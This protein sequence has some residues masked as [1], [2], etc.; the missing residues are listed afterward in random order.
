[1][2]KALKINLSGQIFHIDEDAYEKLRLYLDKISSH[3]SNVEESKEIISDIEARISE[4]F[5]EKVK[6]N[7]QV[8]TIQDVEEIIDIM[9]KPEEIA[10]EEDKESR[11]T[12]SSSESRSNRR[13]YRDP[14]KAVVG[15]VAAGLS[16]YFGL[17]VVVFRIL[18]VVL[19]LVGWGFPLI[20]YIV[21]WIAVPNAIT[22]A[23]KLEMKGEKVNVSNL[24]KKVR[25][26]YEGV[27]DNLKKARSSETARRA[28]SFF[29]EFF[30]IIGVIILLFFKIILAII[31]VSLVIAGISLIA[32]LIGVSFF[33]ASAISF[34]GFGT[35]HLEFNEIIMPF[36]N[37]V[38]LSVIAIAGT[39]LV[40]IPILAILYGLFKAIFKFKTRDRGLGMSA[41]ALW[42][43]ALITT[44][45]LVVVEA[46][47]FSKSDTI[48]T[49]ISLDE[50]TSDTLF[51]S[52]DKN[53]IGK[54]KGEDRL[55]INDKWYIFEEENMIYGEVRLDIE[56]SR[57]DKVEMRIEKESRGT[58]EYEAQELAGNISY[59]YK[60]ENNVLVLDPYFHVDMDDKWRFQ[61]IDITIY[62]PEGKAVNLDKSTSQYLDGIY[63]L[64]HYSSYRMGGMT[65]MMQEDG[66]EFIRN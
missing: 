30:R 41:L 57:S 37:P 54:L 35:H 23:E 39:L 36:L 49:T 51:V 17:D 6:N 46:K 61:N 52:M 7:N 48:S 24:E 9:G 59:S 56:K 5:S 26:E 40:L 43:L 34:G 58:N 63:N 10:D 32:S 3:F 4:H 11:N 44:I 66:L 14:D 22:A 19:I 13:L 42:V 20:L 8:I 45:T 31:A 16:A 28:E 60:V 2:K 15:G 18:F 64:D 33:G 29:H 27:K 53:M 38:N 47:G 21:L 50:L 25:E 65:W 62:L 1:M 55:E 12:Y